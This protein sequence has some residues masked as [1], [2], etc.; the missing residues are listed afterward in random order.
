MHIRSRW[1]A[2]ILALIIAIL[3]TYY[4]RTNS[5]SHSSYEVEQS[6]KM[7]H[8]TATLNGTVLAEADTFEIVEGNIYFPPDSVKKELFS[9]TST[10]SHCPWKGDAHYYSAHVGGQDVK[11]V[12]WF[13][14]APLEKATG[15][16]DYVAFCEY[17][18]FA[19]R[20]FVG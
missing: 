11:D 3:T 10:T 13:Y 8:A 4:Y 7:P 9:E 15:I 19:G 12:A 14:P 6:V 16:K 17:I 18:Y 2:A 5:S 1:T 20:G